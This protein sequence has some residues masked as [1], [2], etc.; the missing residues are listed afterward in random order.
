[1]TPDYSGLPFLFV[2]GALVWKVLLV[3]GALGTLG[4]VL[5]VRRL[6]ARRRVRRDVAARSAAVVARLADGVAVVRGTLRGGRASSLFLS[7]VGATGEEV[8]FH[9]RDP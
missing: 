4:L 6:R 9:E 1:M 5:G 2:H 7:R 8:A 3:V